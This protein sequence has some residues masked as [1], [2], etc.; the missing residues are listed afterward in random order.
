MNQSE[1]FSLQPVRRE[2]KQKKV[3][4]CDE[5]NALAYKVTEHCL[6]PVDYETE[7]E[8][9]TEREEVR[10]GRVGQTKDKRK[11]ER[12]KWKCRNRNNICSGNSHDAISVK[13]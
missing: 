2:K 3:R 13:M 12:Q 1:T 5:E 9:E 4:V 7:E 6:G 11:K 8:T 10:V